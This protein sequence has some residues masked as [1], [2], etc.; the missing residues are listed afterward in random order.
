MHY[1]GGSSIPAIHKAP[2]TVAINAKMPQPRQPATLIPPNRT[3]PSY[4]TC[5]S[6]PIFTP[7]NTAC[8]KMSKIPKNSSQNIASPALIPIISHQ[9]L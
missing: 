1:K 6:P 8:L 4:P 3:H 7:P 2:L 5:P 9:P